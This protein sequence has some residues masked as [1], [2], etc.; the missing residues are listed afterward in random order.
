MLKPGGRFV[1]TDPV[2]ITSQLSNEELPQRSTIGFFLFTP[3]GLNE[4]WLTET[5][6]H[7]LNVE[8]ANEAPLHI[9]AR[10]LQARERRRDTL[11][12]IEGGRIFQGIQAFLKVV[13]KLAR[14][15]R[16]SRYSYL[17]EKPAS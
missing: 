10:W 16:L 5:G 3:P 17:A 7:V 13:H 2:V 9:S 6:F 4:A 15:R 12:R 11:E 14:E 8:D 1:F